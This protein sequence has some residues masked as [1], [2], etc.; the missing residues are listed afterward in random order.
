[1]S[2][3]NFE[4]ME[5][6][7]PLVCGGFYDDYEKEY[8]RQF[9]EKPFDDEVYDEIQY[10]CDFYSDEAADFSKTLKYY[11]VSV[12][13][14]YYDGWQ[15]WVEQND[16]LELNPESPD[17]I[18]NEDA[19]YYFDECR[20]KVLRQA[21]SERNKIQKWL[22]KWVDKKMIYELVCVG[23]FSNGEAVYDEADSLRGIVNAA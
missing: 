10:D 7:M 9:H 5:C 6:G 4:R 1:M 22:K 18:D 17:C 15:F 21:N 14:G 20:S 23:V 2:A 19:H 13:S 11:T 12:E 8:E 3:P 16:G